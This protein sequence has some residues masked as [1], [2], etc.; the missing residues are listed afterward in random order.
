MRDTQRQTQ[1]TTRRPPTCKPHLRS[2]EGGVLSKG[3]PRFEKCTHSKS[4]PERRQPERR[5][6]E[7]RRPERRQPDDANLS[8]ANLYSQPARRQPERRQPARDLPEPDILLGPFS[9]T[10][11]GLFVADTGLGKT[12]VAMAVAFAMTDGQTFLHWSCKRPARVLFIDGEMSKRLLRR[13]I[14]DATKRCVAAT[15]DL[16]FLS[17]EDVEM[18]PPLNTTEGTA[19]YRHVHRPDRRRGFRVFRQHSIA[20][21]RRHEGRR[22]LATDLAVD[23][24]PDSPVR[25]RAN[26]DTSHGT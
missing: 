7:P 18:M 21:C 8:G 3:C 9:T 17:R 1:A 4:G 12:N 26:V 20:A 5:Q 11:R 15:D 24:S 25:Y 6:P 22:K 2:S 23:T 14:R 10:S 13:R 19:V 16:Y